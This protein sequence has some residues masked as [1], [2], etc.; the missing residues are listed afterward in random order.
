MRTTVDWGWPAQRPALMDP[1]HFFVQRSSKGESM[2][3]DR[4]A[5]L[6]PLGLCCMWYF[7][8]CSKAGSDNIAPVTG[9]IT[10]DGSPAENLAVV[11]QPENGRPSMGSTDQSGRYELRYSSSVKGALVGLHTV[12]ISAGAA[13]DSDTVNLTRRITIPAKYNTD[14]QLTADVKP[15]KNRFDFNLDS[16]K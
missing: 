9:I 8:G 7:S 10:I 13:P 5:L 14:S 11:F 6:L 12:L 3:A 1:S 16:E 2:L 4:S 15:G